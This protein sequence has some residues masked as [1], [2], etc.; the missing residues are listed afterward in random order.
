MIKSITVS[1]PNGDSVTI[2]MRSPEQ[3]GF[4]INNIE[5]LTPPSINVNVSESPNVDGGIFNS[6]RANQRNIVISLGFVRT[7]YETI[8]QIRTK[9]YRYFPSKKPLTITVVSDT[10]TA[11]AV[12]YIETNGINIFSRDQGATISIL[13]Q[14]SFLVGKDHVTTFT[15]IEPLFSLPFSNESLVSPIIEFGEVLQDSQKSVIYEGDQPTGVVVV[16]DFVGAVNDLSIVN[17]SQSQTMSISSAK[18]IALTGSDFVAGDRLLINTNR[19]YKS[20]YLFRNNVYTNI[21]NTLGSY[22]DWFTIERGDNV[23]VYVAD[24]GL[25]NVLAYI[26]HTELFEGI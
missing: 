26:V 13:C 21:I 18:L 17:A 22:S 2:D 25:S 24:S 8:E 7:T 10:R 9:L 20:V 12:G 15:G 3:S 11:I 16:M 6:V 5:G 4:F 19:G 1:Q 14:N 23:F